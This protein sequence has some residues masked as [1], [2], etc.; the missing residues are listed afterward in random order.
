VPDSDTIPTSGRPKSTWLASGHT[1]A[2]GGIG[3]V[4]NNARLTGIGEFGR[5]RDFSSVEG[6]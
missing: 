6:G 5:W 3:C 1:R 4:S 2:R